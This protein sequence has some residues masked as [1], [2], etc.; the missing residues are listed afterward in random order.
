M[1]SCTSVRRTVSCAWLVFATLACGAQSFELPKERGGGAPSADQSGGVSGG[2]QGG[3]TGGAVASGASGGAQSAGIAGTSV[4]DR[5]PEDTGDPPPLTP[6]P[7]ESSSPH[8]TG[9]GYVLCAD[10]SYRRPEVGQCVS[11][12]PYVADSDTW[13]GDECLVDT[14]C[15]AE[16]DY[17]KWGLCQHA[18]IDDSECGASEVCFCEEPIGRCIQALCASDADCPDDYPCSGTFGFAWSGFACQYPD[19]E[20]F[21][22]SDCGP[23]GGRYSQCTM[24]MPRVCV[25]VPG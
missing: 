2:G 12:L 24:A 4:V 22:D 6:V 11:H 20:C 9:G 18:C 14:D 1:L 13:L 3:A 25:L 7:C 8:E 10:G 16:H 15:P 21:Q 23:N 17:C 19:D 5:P